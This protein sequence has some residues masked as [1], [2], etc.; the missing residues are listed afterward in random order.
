MNLYLH[1]VLQKLQKCG[2]GG[3]VI[4]NE[5]LIHKNRPTFNFQLTLHETDDERT[6]LI[7]KANV[8]IKKGTVT[9]K[10]N[11][12]NGTE[13]VYLK[14][15]KGEYDGTSSGLVEHIYIAVDQ[16]CSILS[17]SSAIYHYIRFFSGFE[18]LL[19]EDAI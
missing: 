3:M 11:L 2:V 9:F 7:V 15:T 6:L 8:M 19:P 13:K 18:K 14:Y 12:N 5:L 4:N 16:M 10:Y 1:K 17:S